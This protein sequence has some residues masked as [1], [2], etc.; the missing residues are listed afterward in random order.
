MQER[1]RIARSSRGRT[2]DD[3][4]AAIPLQRLWWVAMTKNDC[5]RN[6]LS[7]ILLLAALGGTPSRLP[8]QSAAAN[9]ARPSFEVASIKPNHSTEN[10]RFETSKG[11]SFVATNWTAKNLIEYAY[12]IKDDQ[13]A[14]GPKWFESDSF[15]I[16]AKIEDSFA[17]SLLKL[18]PE[19]HQEQ[20]REMLQSLLAERFNLKITRQTKELPMYGLVV[21]KNG[22]KLTPTKA[23]PPP[24]GQPQRQQPPPPPGRDGSLSVP[25][26]CFGCV[27]MGGGQI[28][29]SGVPISNLADALSMQQ[30]IGGRVVLDKT[31]LNGNYDFALR[32]TPTFSGSGGSGENPAIGPT[33]PPPD[34]SRPS[35]FTAIEEQLGLKLE[36]T[37]GSVDIIVIDHIEEPSPN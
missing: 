37:K 6:A 15:D 32:W 2:W 3:A 30:E 26:G 34:S 13:L 20:V 11:S 23:S 22:P 24:P 16:N 17:Q 18:P 29:A 1:E 35:L 14:G 12:N 4:G 19:Q 33:A 21:A 10:R 8:A 5:T 7:A 9:S 27:M 31:G 36:S 28:V 25:S